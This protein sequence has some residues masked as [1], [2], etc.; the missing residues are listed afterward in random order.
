[1]KYFYNGTFYGQEDKKSMLVDENGIIVAFDR[2]D[3]QAEKVD[4]KGGFAYPGFHDAHLHL[5]ACAEKEFHQVDLQGVKSPQEILLRIREFIEKTHPKEGEWIVGLGWHEAKFDTPQLLSKEDLKELGDANPILLYRACFHIALIN[6]RAMEEMNPLPLEL[7]GGKIDRIGGEPTGILRE[8]ALDL[9]RPYQ[10]TINER[11]E[12]KNEIER[13]LTVLKEKGLTAVWSDDF[14]YVRDKKML[15]EVYQ[16]LNREK[17]LPIR[18]FLQLRVEKKEDLRLYQEMGL[19]TGWRFENLGIASGKIIADG[20]LGGQTAALRE[21]YQQKKE[22]GILIYS[23]DILRTLIHGALDIGID[24]AVHAIGDRTLEMVLNIYEERIEQIRER[25]YR[26][27]IIHCQI[28][29]KHLYE[30]MGALGISANVQPIFIQ[31]DYLI[32]ENYLGEERVRESYNWK[33]LKENGV[34]VY[35]SSD[36]PIEDASI[37]PNL[38]TAIFRRDLDGQMKKA[39]LPEEALAIEE[40]VHMFS[41]NAARGVKQEQILGELKIGYLADMTVLSEALSEDGNWEKI[42]VTRT[43]VGGK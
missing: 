41:Q 9:L 40:A 30:R 15:W 4:L 42:S 14:S 27:S 43:I 20:S 26:P 32:A 3:T 13:Y 1:M 31:S 17:R 21:P 11:E 10:R 16:E 22:R 2:E 37:L 8:S 19:Q 7:E 18:V 25:G 12:I 34:L 36:S 33:T 6:Q 28:G 38:Y 35:G 39:F 29:D 5:L 24:M 23:E